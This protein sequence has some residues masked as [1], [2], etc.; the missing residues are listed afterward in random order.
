MSRVCFSS[1]STSSQ[2]FSSN[3]VGTVGH[4][5]IEPKNVPCLGDCCDD[6][7][8]CERRGGK[9]CLSRTQ[10]ENAARLLSFHEEHGPSRVSGCS[11]D[12]VEAFKGVGGKITEK[13]LFPAWA[14]KAVPNQI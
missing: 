4:N 3:F 13:L 2:A 12:F 9:L 11:F 7:L 6:G 1:E 8:P 5:R 10:Q 14:R